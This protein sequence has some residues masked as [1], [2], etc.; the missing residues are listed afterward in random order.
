MSFGR[1][2][3][4]WCSKFTPP[5]LNS[6]SWLCL[7]YAHIWLLAQSLSDFIILGSAAMK[8]I[9]NVHVAKYLSLLHMYSSVT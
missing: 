9:C 4:W 5:S 2:Q 7:D 8:A 1:C 3:A 6:H